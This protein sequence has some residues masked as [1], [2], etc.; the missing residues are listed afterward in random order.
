VT[1]ATARVTADQTYADRNGDSRGRIDILS[2][3]LTSSSS[4]LDVRVNMR[5]KT[6]NSNENIGVAIDTNGASS[7]IRVLG[8]EGF[9]YLLQ[10]RGGGSG[11][12]LVFRPSGSIWGSPASDPPG[13]SISPYDFG[14]TISASLASL[15]NPSRIRFLIYAKEADEGTTWD[16][17]PDS[18]AWDFVLVTS[19]A[20]TPTPPPPS[21]KPARVFVAKGSSVV[22]NPPRAGGA[23]RVGTRFVYRG[24]GATVTGGQLGCAGWVGAKR[25]S[26][27]TARD[28]GL[29]ACVFQ[30][31]D[32]SGGRMF[33][34][35]VTL[36]VGA[37]QASV[38]RTARITSSSA[39][40]VT[41]PVNSIPPEPTVGRQYAAS[42]L[43]ELMRPGAKP[44]QVRTGGLVAC[45]AT[46]DGRGVR[47]D[48]AGFAN[49]KAYCGWP[50]PAWARGAT[51]VGTITV[52]SGGLTATKTFKRRVN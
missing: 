49:G 23:V 43:V 39:L 27:R 29:R 3:R 30:L 14:G 8:V 9:D 11:T 51:L 35:R 24:S 1:A 31:P 37:R 22:P 19:P 32:S 7:G 16:V 26:A 17:A 4:G 28:A 36:R 21:P 46:A 10:L 38:E 15:G 6:L 42:F 50:I 20:P 45:R 40:R 12:L 5:E 33:K 13:Y 25:V 47:S 18:G 2:A 48:S 52:S 44:V 41:G 34:G